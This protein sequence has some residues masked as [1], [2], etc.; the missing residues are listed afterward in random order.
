MT[1]P[2]THPSR[3]GHPARPWA[4]FGNA[5]RTRIMARAGA[6]LILALAM[7]TGLVQGGHLAYEAS[8]WL[9]LPGRAAGLVGLAA[10]DITIT[11]LVHH[12][13]EALLEA[14]A[15]QPGG[16]LVN[17]DAAAAKQ[18][19][20]SL[21]WIEEATV[22]RRFP[23]Q[24]DIAV[25]ER[26]PFAVWQL[27]GRYQVIDREGRTMSGLQSSLLVSLPLVSGE[28]ANTAAAELVN[29][30]EAH[31]EL[32]LQIDAAARVGGRRWTLYLDS[33]VTVLLPEQGLDSA[34]DRLERL[35]REQ[36]LLAKGVRSIDLRIA[37]RMVVG[38]AE[39]GMDGVAEAG[40]K[41]KGTR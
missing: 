24:L 27:A 29:Q 35:D 13:P 28:G 32:A 19:L 39:V 37:G 30:L 4:E 38:V 6:L 18:Q 15:I 26:D 21:D 1:P 7:A 12:E 22:Q 5:L 31:P 36:G 3:S 10:E 40:G 9:K 14:I 33:G 41:A 34:L 17:F 16:P 23:N 2:A 11:G 25:R 8:P 20:E